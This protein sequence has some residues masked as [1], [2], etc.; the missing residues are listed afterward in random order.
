MEKN[1]IVQSML[2]KMAGPE[3]KKGVSMVSMR[4][5]IASASTPG[6]GATLRAADYTPPAGFVETMERPSP[7]S[8]PKSSVT[9]SDSKDPL[10]NV[11]DD[12]WKI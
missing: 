3:K 1:P 7:Y 5:A 4:S 10:G 11:L 9:F 12:L 2:P 8:K 6:T